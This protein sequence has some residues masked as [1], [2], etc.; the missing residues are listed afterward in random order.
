MNHTPSSVRQQV[1]SHQASTTNL[2]R[3]YTFSLGL[4]QNLLWY[5]LG[6]IYCE[7]REMRRGAGDVEFRQGHCHISLPVYRNLREAF[8]IHLAFLLTCVCL[9]AYKISPLSICMSRTCTGY[10]SNLPISLLSQIELRV[11][12]DVPK[13]IGLLCETPVPTSI[14]T[15]RTRERNSR[16]D[17][18]R[19]CDGPIDVIDPVFRHSSFS[20][21]GFVSTR[22]Q[23]I[24]HREERDS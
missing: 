15:T 20:Q 13:Y 19:G 21:S 12:S 16:F 2:N 22:P 23:D 3:N 7:K 17:R 1:I 10:L 5:C 11:E 4:D 18:S 24:E 6:A 14:S 8:S 9:R